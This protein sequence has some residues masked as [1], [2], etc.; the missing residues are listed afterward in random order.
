MP[1]VRW[2]G[3]TPTQ[4][5]TWPGAR[6]AGTGCAGPVSRRESGAGPDS[7]AELLGGR[8][9]ALDA[10]LPAVGFVAGWLVSGR[11]VAWGVAAAS[12][13]GLVV[14]GLRLRLRRPRAA[15]L[16]LLG[17]VVAGAVAIATGRPE[18]FFVVQVLVNAASAIVW[19]LSILVRWPLLGVVV[20]A[21]LGAPRRWREDPWLLR[22]YAR[23]SWV[24]AGS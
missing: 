3:A 22:A 13:S 17:V 20:G 12:V 24:W 23:G 16:G 5:R 9:A 19:L 18:D 10:S 15:L 7:L 21:V 8:S 2:R 14:A 1:C 4:T 11:S 6:R